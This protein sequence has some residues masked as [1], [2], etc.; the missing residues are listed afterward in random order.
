M[1]LSKKGIS[2]HR[3]IHPDPLDHVVQDCGQACFI[4]CDILD[5]DV[6]ICTISRYL[7]TKVASPV[8]PVGAKVIR[9]SH[10]DVDQ[11]ETKPRVAIWIF[12]PHEG[13]TSDEA[14]KH[15][16]ELER[17]RAHLIEQ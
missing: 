11:W 15:A 16:A 12:G 13:W 9:D 7:N 10:F 14:R 3:Q 4:N 5:T 6:T 2:T 8:F 17:T 1:L